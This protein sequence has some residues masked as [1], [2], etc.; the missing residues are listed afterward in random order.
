MKGTGMIIVSLLGSALF[1]LDA[2]PA[3]Q[4]ASDRAADEVMVRSIVG[5]LEAEKPETHVSPRLDWENAF[6]IRYADLKKRDAFYVSIVKPQFKSATSTTLEPSMSFPSPTVAVADTYWHVAGQV[7]AGQSKAGPDR[8]GRTTYIL[9]K[10]N[11][12]W[13]EAIERVA[14]LRLPFYQHLD[15]VPA[16]VPVSS[17]LL[18]AYAG[19]YIGGPPS[20]TTTAV[21]VAVTGDH[22]TFSGKRGPR[23]AIPTSDSNFLVFLKVD[24]A[25]EYYKATFTVDNGHDR[26]ELC[27]AWG[28]WL[29]VFEKR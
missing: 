6:G 5:N 18:N 17:G 3:T 8:W 20:G 13:T 24:D 23:T 27:E 4:P 19:H 7:Y 25:A 29:G 28:E 14:D 10:E 11:G 12:I 2:D 26:Y 15:A 9:V 16:S 21:D 22:L 1:M